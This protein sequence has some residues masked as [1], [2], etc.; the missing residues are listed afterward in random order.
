MR[1]RSLTLI[2]LLA[3]L[4]G[5]LVVA[6]PV[7]AQDDPVSPPVTA[8]PE[9]GEP[10]PAPAVQPGPTPEELWL[11]A[12]RFPNIPAESGAGRRIV[13]SIGQQRVWL[14]EGGEQLVKTYLV[15][16]RIGLPGSGTYHVYSKSRYSGSGSVRM[17]YMIRFARGRSLA[18]GFHSIPV[19]RRGRPLQRIDQLGTP[20][21][22][23][24][25]RQWIGDAAE[26]WNW[27]PVGTTVVVL[28]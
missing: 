21:S 22:H 6:G 5:P 25:V 27:A 13:Y 15:S 17:E 11:W 7:S 9:P 14:V 12:A 1:I 26:L 10:A 16:G 28:R 23:G 20:R 3:A 19:D 18:I 8:P 24:C 4:V 2:A